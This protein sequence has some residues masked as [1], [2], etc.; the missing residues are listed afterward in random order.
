MP[1]RGKKHEMERDFP[2]L[3]ND[4]FLKQ[5]DI[6]MATTIKFSILKDSVE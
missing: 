2:I 4:K 5:K 6:S 1:V 3:P